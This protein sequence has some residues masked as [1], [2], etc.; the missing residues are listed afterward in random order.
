[1]WLD[2]A[3]QISA[4]LDAA[5]E[6]D[7][8]AQSNR[9]VPRRAI[10]STL[11]FA[12]LRISELAELRWRDVDLA[13]GKITVRTSKTAAGVRRVDLLPILRDELAA[14]KAKAQPTSGDRV[15]PTQSG[16]AL[17]Q[18]NVRNRPSLKPWSALT[19]AWRP[20]RPLHCRKA[21]HPTS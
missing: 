14:H 7:G 5:G 9:R 17:N 18:S 10:V 20:L 12:G 8:E 1:V 21:S 15:F 4:L 16:G 6:L 11:V 3:E 19:S 13:S 2:S